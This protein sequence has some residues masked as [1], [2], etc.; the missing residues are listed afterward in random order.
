[1]QLHDS[2]I[3]LWHV[4]QAGF[5]LQEIEQRCLS[6]LNDQELQRYNRY[7]FDRHR[8]QLLASRLLTRCV[9]SRYAPHI[10][11]PDW[12]FV[13]NDYGKPAIDAAQHAISLYFNLSH[14]GEKLVLA[15][16][17]AEFIGVDIESSIKRRRV[18]RIADRFFSKQEVQNLLALPQAQRQSRF[19]ELWT[20]KEA[21]IK[22][23]GLGLAIPL[24]Q[25]S[26]TFPALDK[27][28][29]QF[30]SARIDD[31]RRWQFWQIDAGTDYRM[32]LAIKNE[33]GKRISDISSRQMSG[34][35]DCKM[36]DTRII[37]ST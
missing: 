35:N 33:A 34:L 18:A 23:C 25:F 12:R 28:T 30:D 10:A 5:S 6:W 1:M 14:S 9:L 11:P 20:L 8:K 37:R 13:S 17:A 3:H 4:D 36:C 29:I 15:V 7:Y 27:L 32:A 21:Y 26:Y 2:E 16:T 19:Y 24:R 22:A 31:A